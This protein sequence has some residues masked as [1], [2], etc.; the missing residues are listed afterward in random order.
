[1]WARTGSRPIALHQTDYEWLYVWAAVDPFS[2][3]C[4]L[5]ITPTVNTDLMNRFLADLGQTLSPQ[6]HAIMILDNAGWHVADALKVPN[7]ITLLHL[8]PYSPEL[9]A[10]ERLWHH[11]R[12]HHLAN[13]VYADY[14]DIFRQVNLACDSVTPE[15]IKTLCAVP[16]LVH[17]Y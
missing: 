11:L 9:N 5:M 4:H 12:S 3:Q 2:G 14:S 7:N 15:L 1:V 13:R 16:W 6:E 8:P 10:S 17:P